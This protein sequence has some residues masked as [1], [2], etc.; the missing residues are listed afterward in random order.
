MTVPAAPPPHD[1]RAARLDYLR[2]LADEARDR[3]F[4]RRHLAEIGREHPGVCFDYLELP[5]FE[6]A[7]RGVAAPAPDMRHV[8]KTVAVC[9]PPICPGKN[10]R[11][12]ALLWLL[13]KYRRSR[14]LGAELLERIRRA[15]LAAKYWMDEPGEDQECY[16]TEN[17][18][19]LFHVCEYLAGQT[20]PDATFS[21]NGRDGRWHRRH[22]REHLDRWLD[23]RGRFG[24]S[25]WKAIGYY[26]ADLYALLTLHEFADDEALRTRAAAL[27]DLILFEVAMHSHEGDFGCT[28]GRAA[29]YAVVRGHVGKLAVVG[30]VLW[31]VGRQDC[32]FS[33]AAVLLCCGSYRLPEAVRAVAL[34]RRAELE[35]RERNSLNVEDAAAHGVDPARPENAMFFWGNQTYDHRE[36]ID[37]SREVCPFPTYFMAERIDAW[38]EHYRLGEAAGQPIDP[39]PD[40]T[41][42]T[43][44]NVYTY[45]TPHYMLS[46][47]Q[48]YRRG[49]PGMSQHIWQATLGGGAIV[50]TTHPG[51]LALD[52]RPSYWHGNGFLPKAVACRNVLVCIYRT[53]PDRTH[54]L[55][56]HAYFPRHL[57]DEVADAGPW[58]F[59]R[60]GEG[61][62][63]LFS[64]RPARWKPPDPEMVARMLRPHEGHAGAADTPCDRFA[65]GHSNVWICEL[66]HAATHGSFR[67]FRE[68]IEAARVQGD[69]HAVAYE[70]PSLGT[71]ATGWDRPLTVGGRAVRTRGYQRFET[72]YCRSAFG[73]GAYE[74]ACDGRR[75]RLDLAAGARLVTGR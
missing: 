14:H 68:A 70:S 60:K 40:Y 30:S 65:G 1:P 37:V 31:G 66:G 33:M 69:H 22:A 51:T 20:F 24:F 41:A 74:I 21:N 3:P 38:S 57:F 55:C 25:E 15:V 72:P 63:A 7:R 35:V 50:F 36:V 8:E 32:E 23:W 9:T 29:P 42:L 52:G 58:V 71:V 18:Q 75:V 10:W 48:D 11:L 49:R 6:L 27:C 12:P 26:D 28:H 46:C 43:E 4:F 64:L 73:A 62:V 16:F 5:R 45:R 53:P 44:A 59:G 34:D 67:D 39:D 61:Y 13:L 17:H 56:T 47:A 19:V 2:F 54:L